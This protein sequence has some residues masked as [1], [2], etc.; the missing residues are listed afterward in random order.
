MDEVVEL[1]RLPE[2]AKERAVRLAALPAEAFL[3]TKRQARRVV[4][5]F[6]EKHRSELDAEVRRCWSS[7]STA[8]RIRLY[9]SRTLRK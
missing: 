6:L 9:I 3:A 4:T 2:A 7:P 5:D 1:D 8:E